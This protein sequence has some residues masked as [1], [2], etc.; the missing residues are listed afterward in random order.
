MSSCPLYNNSNL[1]NTSI[2]PY[3]AIQQGGKT[4]RNKFRSSKLRKTRSKRRSRGRTQRRSRG[5]IF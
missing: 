4:R 2:N 3:A 1:S 5:Y